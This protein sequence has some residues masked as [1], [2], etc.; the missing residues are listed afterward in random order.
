MDQAELELQLK[1]WKDLAISKQ[2]LMSAATDALGLNPDCSPDKLKEALDKTIKQGMNADIIVSEAREKANQAEAIM[3]KKMAA[4]DKALAAAEAIK[5][6]AIAA[7]KKSENDMS[8]E[9]AAHIQE[10]KKIKALIAEKESALK[11]IKKSLGD[12]PENVVKKLK[13]LKKQ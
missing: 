9:R 7:Q 4:N 13:T 5:A 10:M 2:I 8:V 11:A 1:V 3:E 6:G 12:S